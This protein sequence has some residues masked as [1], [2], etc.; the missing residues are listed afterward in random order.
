[1]NQA[2]EVMRIEQNRKRRGSRRKLWLQLAVA[3]AMIQ[4]ALWTEGR[5]QQLVSLVPAIWIVGVTLARGRQAHELGVGSAGLVKALRVIPLGLMAAGLIV[6][7]GWLA[8]TIHI[9]HSPKTPRVQITGYF[10]WTIAQ[11]FIL[12]SFFYVNLEELLGATRAM[13]AA[14]ALFTLAHLPNPVLLVGTFLG[15]MFFVEMFRRY[16]NIYPIAVSHAL[17]GLAILVSVP[18]YLTRHMRVGIGFL[19]YRG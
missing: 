18:D 14:V 1:M 10:I 2:A 16:R 9:L 17:L 8:G 4:L 11:Q 6:L 7:A 15:G 12:Q 19:R 13:W 5:T 3:Y